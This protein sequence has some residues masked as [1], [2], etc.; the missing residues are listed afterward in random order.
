LKKEKLENIKYIGEEALNAYNGSSSLR[1]VISSIPYIGGIIDTILTTNAQEISSRRLNDFFNQLSNRMTEVEEKLID[2]EFIKSEE[3]YD[4][5]FKIIESSQRTRIDEK[6]KLYSQILCNACK[7]NKEDVN[8][9]FY[10]NVINELTIEELIVAKKLY[11]LKVS[12]EYKNIVSK[13]HTA[14]DGSMG[15]A[16]VLTYTELEINH[17]ELPFILLRLQKAGLIKEITGT[18]MGYSGGGYELTETFKKLMNSL[19]F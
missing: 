1:F 8:P 5:L 18:Y 14:G 16:Q 13:N 7:I 19:I 2:L 12:G 17:E 15:T 6:R 9:E 11:E 10:I 4:L 3:F